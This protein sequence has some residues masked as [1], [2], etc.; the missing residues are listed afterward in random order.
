MSPDELQRRLSEGAASP[1]VRAH[2]DQQQAAL[3]DN[4]DI[5]TWW[6]A[7]MALAETRGNESAKAMALHNLRLFLASR[8]EDEMSA[9][10]SYLLVDVVWR[11]AV[12]GHDSDIPAAVASMVGDQML[13]FEKF[14]ATNGASCPACGADKGWGDHD[15]GDGFDDVE[16][17]G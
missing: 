17:Q 16:E 3:D 5:G 9:L 13:F 1:A 8:R 2:L 7:L 12:A 11:H 14:V 4:R 10:A 6:A 15:C